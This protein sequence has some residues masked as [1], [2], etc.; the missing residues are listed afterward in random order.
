METVR[1][2]G[3]PASPGLASETAPV[4][5]CRPALALFD[6]DNT[7]IDRRGG[8]EDWARDLVAS[9]CLSQEAEAVI[10]DRLRERAYPADF[11][12]LRETLGL[13]DAP[14]DLWREYVEGVAGSVRCFPGVR[15]GL[16]SLRR[17]GWIIGIATNGRTPRA[18]IIRPQRTLV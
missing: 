11:V 4:A 6:L 15:E 1:R 7:L 14:D 16:E 13:S 12:Y 17:T 5:Y 18:A 10:R 2:A 3:T 9:R 8:M